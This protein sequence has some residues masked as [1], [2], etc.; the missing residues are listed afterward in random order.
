MH[1]YLSD[2]VS[3]SSMNFEF[4]PNWKLLARIDFLNLDLC[5]YK[6]KMHVHF[7]F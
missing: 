2:T 6:E 3:M 5:V 4:E 7:S 1:K